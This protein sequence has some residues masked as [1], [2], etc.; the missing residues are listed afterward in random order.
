MIIWQGTCGNTLT[1]KAVM[2]SSMLIP[3][4]R[5]AALSTSKLSSSNA[6]RITSSLT[7]GHRLESVANASLFWNEEGV[8]GQSVMGALDQL[9]MAV[10]G[11]IVATGTADAETK[12]ALGTAGAA[13]V[14]TVSESMPPENNGAAIRESGALCAYISGHTR[15]TIIQGR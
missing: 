1:R 9:V 15:R 11:E 8:E 13:P 4:K 5:S 7:R 3:S 10:F 14:I 12:S 2:A 6:M